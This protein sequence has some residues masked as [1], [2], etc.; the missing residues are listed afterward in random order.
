MGQVGAGNPRNRSNERHA[1]EA[2]SILES[3]PELPAP[4]WLN[5]PTEPSPILTVFS[6]NGEYEVDHPT[7]VVIAALLLATTAVTAIV[8]F[9]L[10]A[11]RQDRT[12]ATVALTSSAL[13]PVVLMVAN[14]VFS[15]T[16]IES[17][18]DDDPL[19]GWAVGCWVLLLASLAGCWI[20]RFLRDQFDT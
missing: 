8:A 17:G 5:S 6:L 12:A 3:H 15:L 13:L 9:L 4:A 2:V 19:T 20:A 18:S 16:D 1:N 7:G 14:T 10:A 11:G